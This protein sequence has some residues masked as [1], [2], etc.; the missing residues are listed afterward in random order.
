MS[1][2]SIPVNGRGGFVRE[3]RVRAKLR[4]ADIAKRTNLSDGYVARIE[5]DPAVRPPPKR[6]VA[7]A[8]ALK[9]SPAVLLEAW[10]YVP[11]EVVD[12][13]RTTPEAL[14]WFSRLSA[15]E[16]RKL[17]DLHRRRRS[18]GRDHDERALRRLAKRYGLPAKDEQ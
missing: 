5:I 13:L 17:R 1:R 7:I 4:Q 3:L 10:G 11:T 18:D 15:A 2:P 6:I 14:L 12:A 9:V 8:E 16:R